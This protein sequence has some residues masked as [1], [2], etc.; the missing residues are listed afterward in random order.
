M[1]TDTTVKEKGT[2]EP[3]IV[4]PNHLK[5]LNGPRMAPEDPLELLKRCGAS[6]EGG[7]H[8]FAKAEQ[9]PA[10]IAYFASLLIDR[11]LPL[12]PHVD[13]FCGIPDGGLVLGQALASLCQRRSVFLNREPLA[14]RLQFNR[15]SL[16]QED[17]VVLVYDQV[18]WESDAIEAVEKEG[19]TV[20]L[21]VGFYNGLGALKLEGMPVVSVL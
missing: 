4:I 8:H 3:G 5:R 13:V 10:V 20:T 17:R 2:Q 1:T 6:A 18:G 19:G 21:I 11:M 12:I 9:Y 7:L 15:H 16:Q 14:Q